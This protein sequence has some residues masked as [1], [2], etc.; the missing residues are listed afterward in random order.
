[1]MRRNR[2]DGV[3]ETFRQNF[4]ESPMSNLTQLSNSEMRGT[5]FNGR[6][7]VDLF[8]DNRN[9]LTFTGSFVRGK[10]E[11]GDVIM[12]TTEFLYPDNSV[13]SSYLRSS[14]QERMFRNMGGAMLFK[15]LFPKKGAEWTADVHFNKVRFEGNSAYLTEYDSGI[16]TQE[17]QEVL[18]RGS[19]LTLQSDF[20]NP[21]DDKTKLEGGVKATLRNNRN[22]NMSFFL[23]DEHLWIQVNQL[24]DHYKFDNN[25]YAAYLQGSR[26]L[27]KWGIQAGLRAESSFYRGALTDRDSSFTISYPFCLFPS[28]FL[29]HKL[30]D[31]EQ[32]QLSYTR[33]VNRPN[34]FQTMPFT[35]FSDS[36]NLRRGN[37][38][39]L[40]EFTNSV[41]FSYQKIFKS[42][43]NIL[44]SIYYKQATDLIASY[45]FTEYSE[46]LQRDVVITSYANS[47]MASAY[48]AEFT[49]KNSFFDVVELTTNLNVYRSEVD[50]TNVETDLM[51]SRVSAFLKE[52]VQIVLPAKFS[53]QI[54]G[55]Y[56]TRASF[57]PVTN[58]EPF[59]GGGPP[60]Q[61]TAQGYTQSY[62]FADVSLRKEFLKSKASV[63]LSVQ[64]I[65][66][67]REFGSYISTDFFTQES[68]RIMNP[69]QVRL[70]FSYRF[71]R[72]D[73]SLLRRKNNRVNMEGNDMMQ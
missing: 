30:N 3:G 50:A 47:D 22:D 73:V 49:V 41:E 21:L 8:L 6:A 44:V 58:N 61:N 42:G 69:Q 40:P 63:T 65:F 28:I 9:T 38:R 4:F 62:W 10:F 72:M 29:T 2:G 32:F 45:Q 16:E 13:L 31:S 60:S 23:D 46:D 36:L 71:G 19:F 55:E 39:L 34:F 7:G 33:R 25:V 20:I 12:T 51:V 37:P 27:D 57:T 11:P 15:H 35:D 24:S 14:D 70:N 5:F 26:Q 17:R 59:R 67:T 54:N 68:S 43:H 52:T 53:L 1:M 56:R 64:D 18:G 66:S 48:G